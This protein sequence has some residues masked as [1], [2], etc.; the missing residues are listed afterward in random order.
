M[1]ALGPSSKTRGRGKGRAY[2]SFDAYAVH[3]NPDNGPRHV[4]W[5][6]RVPN[7]ARAELENVIRQRVEKLANFACLGNAIDFTD[8]RHAGG[9]AKYT[10][11][12]VHPAFA[13]HFH[14]V[15]SDQ[16]VV[17]GR[18]ITISRSIGFAAR[19]RAGWSRKSKRAAL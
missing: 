10:L 8:V 13:A 3:E 4:H 9:V 18:R 6:M 2:G 11:K 1:T 15:A 5:V 17:Q 16:G 12:G 7:G 19:Q 14:M